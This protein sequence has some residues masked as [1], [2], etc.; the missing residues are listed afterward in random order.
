MIARTRINQ[1]Q[2]RYFAAG[3]CGLMAVFILSHWLRWLF[4]NGK[5]SKHPIRL[6]SR[7]VGIPELFLLDLLTICYTCRIV[8]NVLVRKV[9]G[10]TSSGHALVVTCYVAINLAI[11][12]TNVQISPS[13]IA[14]RCGW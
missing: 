7:F 14:N 10:F 13:S 2:M 9:S 5:S 6:L 11:T 8:R 1:Q 12:F 3:I 4:S